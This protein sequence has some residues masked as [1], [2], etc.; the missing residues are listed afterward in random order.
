MQPQI[1]NEFQQV[2]IKVLIAST[3]SQHLLPASGMGKH[4]LRNKKIANLKV[5][6]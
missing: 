6:Y 5:G 4:L 1:G 2:N 3:T